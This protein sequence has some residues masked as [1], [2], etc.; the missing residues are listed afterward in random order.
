VIDGVHS[1]TT[2]TGPR[3]SLGAHGVVLSSGLK[4]RLVD[5]STTGD[6][7]DDGSASRADDLWGV[8]DGRA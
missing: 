2:S 1:N 4:E 6:N 8:R 3:V 5:T 7:T